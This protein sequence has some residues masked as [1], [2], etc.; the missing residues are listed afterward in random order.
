M[1]LDGRNLHQMVVNG[2]KFRDKLCY[3]IRLIRPEILVLMID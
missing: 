3:S 1:V 2:M